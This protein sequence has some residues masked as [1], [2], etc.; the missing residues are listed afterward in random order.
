MKLLLK[1]IIFLSNK[2]KVFKRMTI[3]M[4]EKNNIH[5]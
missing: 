2:D 4:K 3:E 1:E 5:H